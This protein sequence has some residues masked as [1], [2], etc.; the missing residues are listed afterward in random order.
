MTAAAS[1]GALGEFALS[2]GGALT[3][4]DGSPLPASIVALWLAF[5]ATFS[6]SL[7]WLA[8]RP[9]LAAAFALVGAPM[10]YLGAERL[11]AVAVTDG[12]LTLA[13][14]GAVWALTLPGAAFLYRRAGGGRR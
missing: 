10:S 6:L 4:P 1:L 12:P 7:G 8:S 9:R 2:Q 11:G 5:A 3:F 14:I 13:A